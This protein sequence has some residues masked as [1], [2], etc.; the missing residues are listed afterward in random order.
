MTRAPSR[1]WNACLPSFLSIF[2]PLSIHLQNKQAPVTKEQGERL[3]KDIRAFKYMECSAMTQEGL[4][5]R[6]GA[7][8]GVASCRMDKWAV[9]GSVAQESKHISETCLNC[10][11]VRRGDC[12][13]ARPAG[14][15]GGASRQAVRDR[16]PNHVI[17]R[18]YRTENRVFHKS[19]SCQ[20]GHALQN[21][22][23]ASSDPILFCPEMEL[24]SPFQWFVEIIFRLQGYWAGLSSH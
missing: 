8:R 19:S 10:S 1:S 12:G 16:L 24:F 21:S 15:G 18:K 22:D 5:G 14:N 2:L 4:K 23:R 7:H 17:R 11:R 20:L 3:A 13:V 6:R 9:G